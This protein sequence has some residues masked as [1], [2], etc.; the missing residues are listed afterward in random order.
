MNDYW[1]PVL[2]NFNVALDYLLGPHNDA[3][4]LIPSFAVVVLILLW[5]VYR[6]VLQRRELERRLGNALL[7]RPEP[8]TFGDEEPDFAPDVEPE[9]A[10]EPE[11]GEGEEALTDEQ[12]EAEL[13][14]EAVQA[15]AVEPLPKPEAV[16]EPEAAPEAVEPVAEPVEPVVE[17][18]V[19]PEPIPVVEEPKLSFFQRLKQGLAK[20]SAGLVGKIDA[21]IT[22][23]KEIDDD[24]YE[25]LEE[26][27]VTA[28]IGVQTAYK[29]L[30]NTR[31]TV[32][33]KDLKDP[34][35]LR[36]VL[37]GQILEIVKTE[38]IP[39]DAGSAKPFVI[40]VVGVNG[41]GKTTTIGKIAAKYGQEG[42]KVVIAAGDTF[43]AAAIE[44]LEVWAN[45]A[46]AE[47][48]KQDAGADP[49]AVAYDAVQAGV[50][51]GADVVIVDTAGRLH[52]KANLME[53]LKKI[54]RVMSKIVPDAPHE[55]VLVLDATTGQNAINQA[56]VF[57]D[58]IELTGL[59]LT[60]LDGTSKGGCIVGICDELQVPIRMIGIGEK[61]DDLRPFN[62]VEFVDAMFGRDE[63]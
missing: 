51:R 6:Q 33:R 30:E 43:R 41:V 34:A 42:K 52:T 44:Q 13:A 29:L 26:A 24:L 7:G 20:T 32:E 17:E 27:L 56:K 49:S 48:V 1:R 62:A 12:I 55:T 16:P 15:E 60:K 28:D 5:V 3:T 23:R 37:K 19:E 39:M 21:V 50:S 14:E 57:N 11:W 35:A 4:L 8:F 2:E 54:K 18:V 58:A 45:R 10:P 31:E 47:I 38:A 46:G 40:M 36:D 59:I 25:D 53:E 22:G 63:G 61:V 9:A